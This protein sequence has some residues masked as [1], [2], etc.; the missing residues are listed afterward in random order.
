MG[1][2]QG[3]SYVWSHAGFYVST[4]YKIVNLK[5]FK[6]FHGYA[7]IEWC[8]ASSTSS[9]Q[10]NLAKLPQNDWK[11]DTRNVLKKC[12]Y[13]PPKVTFQLFLKLNSFVFEAKAI[14][15]RNMLRQK[16]S[17]FRIE[18]SITIMYFLLKRRWRE[19]QSF[20]S[21]RATGHVLRGSFAF[22]HPFCPHQARCGVWQAPNRW[23]ANL[24]HTWQ[25]SPDSGLGF[26]A[27]VLIPI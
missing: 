2:S 18:I 17:S 11:L 12:F 27:K 14:S 15:P 13:N 1:R 4:K 5:Q 24:A 8:D 20:Q 10:L 19:R 9:L 26:Q 7:K 25:S 3:G 6:T 22:S 16:V 23:L 21:S